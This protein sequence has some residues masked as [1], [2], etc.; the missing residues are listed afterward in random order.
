MQEPPSTDDLLAL[1]LMG[2][3]IT[4][5]ELKKYPHGKMFDVDPVAAPDVDNGYRFDLM[6][7]DVA[8]ELRQFLEFTGARSQS[9]G[10]RG[11]TARRFLLSSRRMPNVNCSVGT[12][13]D[14]F[15]DRTPINPL[16]MHPLDLEEINL[17]CGEKVEVRSD[18]GTIIAVV[19]ADD[20]MRR[21][22]VSLPHG[23]GGLPGDEN[24]TGSCVNRLLD[25]KNSEAINAMPWM[26]A[27]PV[28]VVGLSGQVAS[29]RGSESSSDARH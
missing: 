28:D 3:R 20:S 24:E 15:L 21:G 27:I 16:Y 19:E 22:V 13:V 23:W 11:F 18:S 2:G 9:S 1:R 29:K 5:E 6:P 4:L 10:G 7:A 12:H 26:S 8:E 17:V 25:C 14:S